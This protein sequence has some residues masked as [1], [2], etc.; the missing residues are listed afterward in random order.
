MK[1]PYKICYKC[2]NFGAKNC[3]NS[4]LCFALEDKPYFIPKKEITFINRLKKIL[5]NK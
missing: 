4:F 2:I 3:P 5:T 1:D